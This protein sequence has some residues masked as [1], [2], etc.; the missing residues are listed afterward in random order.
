MV[1][2]VKTNPLLFSWNFQPDFSPC[3]EIAEVPFINSFHGKTEMV[4]N[5]PL[6]I[7]F[8]ILTVF[9]FTSGKSMAAG[10]HPGSQNTNY[11]AQTARTLYRACQFDTLDDFNETKAN[12]INIIDDEAREECFNTVQSEPRGELRPCKDQKDARR[13]ACDSI[14]EQRYADPLNDP[15]ITF[16]DPEDIGNGVDP[17]PYVNMA[18][19]HTYVLRAGE[20]FEETVVVH[21]TDEARE[22]EGYD[23]EPVLCRVVVD[24][25][26][27]LEED[28][29]EGSSEW[30][31]EEVTDDYFAQDN[32]GIVY[33]CG[34]ISRNFEDGYLSNLDGSFFSGVEHAEAGVLMRQA[35]A[36]GQAD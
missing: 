21:V 35:P 9:T 15:G 4:I 8:S 1:S 33:Y 30:V 3:C 31:G 34:E 7:A 2:L 14:G 22:A 19:G 36:V 27:I 25:V 29:E 5:K 11:C 26:M 20:D 12:C 13:G 17:N 18:V 6:I 24:A 32:T 28:E 10:Y 16:V 23:G